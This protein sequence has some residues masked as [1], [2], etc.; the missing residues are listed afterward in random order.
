MF[1]KPRYNCFTLNC[2]GHSCRIRNVLLINVI[3]YEIQ[4]KIEKNMYKSNQRLRLLQIT[5]K[6]I[7]VNSHFYSFML[8]CSHKEKRRILDSSGRRLPWLNVENHIGHNRLI[9]VCMRVQRMRMTVHKQ[10][11]KN[12]HTETWYFNME[13]LRREKHVESTNFEQNHYD[14]R[15]TTRSFKATTLSLSSSNRRL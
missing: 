6:R 13:N 8:F 12:R 4:N 3:H 15:C 9:F 14:E 2:F 10:T 5:K 11:T 1:A 7:E